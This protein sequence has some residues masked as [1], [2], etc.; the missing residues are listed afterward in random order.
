MNSVDPRRIHRS[1][2]VRICLMGLVIS[3]IVGAGVWQMEKDR[4]G[5]EILWNA[6]NSFKH[7]N[8]QIR[9]L[10]NTPNNL[11]PDLLQQQLI[12][13]GKEQK[14]N[15]SGGF[16]SMAIY[17][18]SGELVTMITDTAYKNSELVRDKAGRLNKEIKTD[19]TMK[20]SIIQI[21]E[22]PYMQ[23]ISPL[24]NDLGEL[25]AY[26]ETFFAVAPETLKKTRIKAIK[27]ASVAILIVVFTTS[28]LYPIVVTLLN[29]VSS[30]SAKLFESNLEMLKVLG[31]AVAKR[32]SDTDSHN[33]RVTII[34][35]KLAEDLRL[36]KPKIQQLIKGAFLHDIGKIGIEDKILHK[37]SRLN[38]NEFMAMKNHVPYGIDI[39]NKAEWLKEAIDIVGSH[40]EKF[41]GSGYGNGLKKEQIPEIARIFSIADVFDAL[42]SSRPYKA[43]FS[44]EKAM[45]IIKTGSGN[46]FDPVYVIA[47]EK[48]AFSLFATYA[49]REDTKLKKELATIIQEYFYG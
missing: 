12:T 33:Y 30:L 35:V 40:H 44:F 6:K 26:G 9:S 36:S 3:C 18:L 16:V 22:T 46:H 4:I 34:S 14:Q 28:L 48:I 41:D 1:L 45:G 13:T 43:P 27:L 15:Q 20:F 24:K 38:E 32:D 49:K 17:T 5:Q 47:F 10:L 21:E 23:I 29:R 42:T 25:A 7:F 37:P 2:L 8:N 11:N 31:S 39:V 19:N